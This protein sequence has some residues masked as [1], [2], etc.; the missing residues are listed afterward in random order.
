[1][2]PIT[3]IALVTA[4]KASR[5]VMR[6]MEDLGSSHRNTEERIELVAKIAADAHQEAVISVNFSYPNHKIGSST[7]SSSSYGY[8]YNDYIWYINPISGIINYTHGLPHFAITIAVQHNKKIKHAIIYDPIRQEIFATTRGEGAYLN[9]RRI[10]VSTCKSLE[11][12]IINIGSLGVQ[13]SKLPEGHVLISGSCALDLAYVASG[14][15]DG[16]FADKL[17]IF[18]LAAGALLIKEAGGLITD[19]NGEEN[20]FING[21]VIASNPKLMKIIIKSFQ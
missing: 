9:N 4:R 7:N 19:F 20:Y 16:F 5:I 13:K 12:S 21:N 10:R 17:N 1:M 14:R 11:A 15:I 8:G 2:H 6:A 3:N 18:D